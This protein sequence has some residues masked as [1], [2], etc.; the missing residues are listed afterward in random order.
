MSSKVAVAPESSH[1]DGVASR[2][3]APALARPDSTM[4]AY[5]AQSKL[6]EDVREMMKMSGFQ[7]MLE[8]DADMLRTP[9]D[10]MDY[11]LENV[12]TI[13]PNGQFFAIA[14]FTGL[15]IGLLG[16]WEKEA[17]RRSETPVTFATATYTAFQVVASGGQD[18]SIK[19]TEHRILFFC[20]I[21]SGLVV[22]AILV[23]FI[24]ES[25]QEYM[26]ALSSGRS[27][28]VEKGHTL[29]LGT[30]ARRERTGREDR[31]MTRAHLASSRAQDGTNRPPA[32]CARSRFFGERGACKT[33][34]GIGSGSRG[35]AS[36]PRRPWQK[37]ASSS[38]ATRSPSTRWRRS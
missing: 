28:V 22:F 34:R 37:R 1:P 35:G 11:L 3:M 15:L 21:L 20:M 31:E 2:A 12:L 6:A 38:C 13:Y 29:I 33:R 23:G 17:H 25:V 27:K 26:L 10:K 8:R 7:S 36:L 24:T 9:Q 32:W 14:V 30:S 18:L 19:G 5:V 16:W 4:L